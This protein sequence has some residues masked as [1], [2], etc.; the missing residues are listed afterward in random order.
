MKVADGVPA[1]LTVCPTTGP[2]WQ[3][4]LESWGGEPERGHSNDAGRRRLTKR[5]SGIAI[6]SC[7]VDSPLPAIC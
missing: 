4:Y 1:F 3:Q 5:C 2:A 6:E 7:G